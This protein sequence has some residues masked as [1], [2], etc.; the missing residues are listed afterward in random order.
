METTIIGSSDLRVSRLGFGCWQ[1]GGHGW[2]GND[3]Q[4]ITDAICSALELGVNFFDTADIYGMGASESLLGQTLASHTSGKNAVVATKFGV[5]RGEQGSFYDNSREW[6]AEAVEA[7][8]RRLRRETI[9]LYQIHWHDG[10]RPL[11]DIFSDLEKLRKQG[12]IRWYGISNIP[13]SALDIK[14]IPAGLAGF[15][16]KYSLVQRENEQEILQAQQGGKLSFI[17]WGSLTQGV[18]S[19][20]YNR[21]SVFAGDDIRSR[22]DSL[23]AEKNWDYYEPVLAKLKD[24][25]EENNKTMSQAA[26]RFVLDYMPESIVLAGIKNADQLQENVGATDWHLPAETIK[27]LAKI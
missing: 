21:H 8:L 11:A 15:T 13:P 4:A 12:K 23:F 5:R 2:Q 1:L 22:A 24:I 20:K 9:D 7:S 3:Q 14:N 27:E 16:M 19:G 26:L 18:L 17:A 6:I 25:A 10:K